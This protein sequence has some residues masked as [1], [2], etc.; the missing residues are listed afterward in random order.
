MA[1]NPTP[2]VPETNSQLAPRQHDDDVKTIRLQA[3]GTGAR[4][5]WRAMGPGI[6]AAMT[7]IGASHIMH[8][9]TAGAQYGYALLWIIPFAYFF[10]Y[11]AFEFA[12]RYTMVRGES[13]MEGY[14][15]IGRGKGNWPLWY[16][17]FQAFANTFGI[18]GRTLGC[19]A[20]LWA[21]FP[22]MPL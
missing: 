5:T 17:L 19:A 8:A 16:L 4:D 9:P 11:C 13:I 18:A 21:A 15:R 10:K 22:I 6:A 7:G 12:H 14:E 20:L 3:P 1:V 2:D